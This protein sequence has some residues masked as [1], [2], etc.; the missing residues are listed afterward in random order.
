MGESK[1]SSTRPRAGGRPTSTEAARLTERLRRAAFDTF[2]EHGYDATTMEAVAQAAGITKG[3]LYSRYA[4]KRALFI[5]V[6][7]W[8]LT[9][10]ER[11]EPVA[12][13]LPDDLAEALTV[14]AHAILARSV[15]PDLV[16]L[17]RMS[18]A[19]AG[20]F[21][22]FAASSQAV[23]W[24][25]RIK[26]LIDLLR[27]HQQ[28]GTIAVPDIELAAEQFFAQVGA[29][30][31]WLA[32]YGT[33]RSPEDEER[34][35]RH[36]VR[37]FLNGVLVRQEGGPAL[38]GTVQP[39]SESTPEPTP[40]PTPRPSSQPPPESSAHKATARAV[41]GDVGATPTPQY[42]RVGN[43]GLRVS[44]IGL[45]A[46]VFGMPGSGCDERTAVELIHRYLD[47][48]GNLVQTADTHGVAEEI[49]GRA[50]RDRRGDAVLATRVAPP[51]TSDGVN[52]RRHIRAACDASL[53]RL[54]TDHIDLYQLHVDD[55][56]TPLE[57]TIGALD[58][59]VRAGK[60]LYVGA[61][62]LHA[63]RLMKALA[64]SD[65]LGRAR[66]VSYQGRYG[67]A[68]RDLEREHFPLLAEEGVGFI[69]EGAFPVGTTEAGERRDRATA[70]HRIA[71][72]LGCTPGQLDLA[73]QCTRPIAS[74]L[75]QARTPAE[76]DAHL[77]A[78]GITMPPEVAAELD[79]WDEPVR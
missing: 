21:P 54:G 70:V 43:S 75:V 47:A 33:Q 41:A 3:T 37:L 36:A 39:V 19:V 30:P 50:L 66:F 10:H 24:T 46:T 4:D 22:E 60:V 5:A 59:L 71:A 45:D 74:V 56:S 27:R 76:L 57:E 11:S 62:N 48:G 68:V 29:M 23:T 35:I 61:A 20:R 58:E 77:V 9:R 78:A 65:R 52:S 49:C 8:A 55:P 28:A 40:E 25:P 63:Y 7:K 67:S 31:A 44:C 16:R 79:R 6:T 17:S 15:D 72:E 2:L 34:H 42:R 13:P 12:E 73:W 1:A 32:A 38:H 14:M 53:R 51:T 18:I 26:V 64:V 69:S